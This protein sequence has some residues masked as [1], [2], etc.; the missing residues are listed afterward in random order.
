MSMIDKL[1]AYENDEMTQ[2]ETISFFQELIDTGLI[3]G[4]QGH[5]QR[6]AEA[7]LKAGIIKQKNTS[8]ETK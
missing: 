3:S 7:L 4:L 8:K 5:Y 6:T 2:E 1:V